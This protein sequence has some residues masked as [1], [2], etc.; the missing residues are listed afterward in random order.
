MAP[1]TEPTKTNKNAT[2]KKK[3]PGGLHKKHLNIRV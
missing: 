2:Q 1:T 3:Q